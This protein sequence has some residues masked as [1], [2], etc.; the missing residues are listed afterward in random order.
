MRLGICQVPYQAQAWLPPVP[1]SDSW[2]ALRRLGITDLRLQF[3]LAAVSPS[4][5]AWNTA[6]FAQ[7][8]RPAR[9][10]GLRVCANIVM[11]EQLWRGEIP[12][13]HH[14]A[15]FRQE[16]ARRLVGELGDMIDSYG[17]GNEPGFGPWM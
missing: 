11:G 7:W 16:A 15:A 9:A 5:G 13:A 1:N 14:D 17:L 3:N 2:Q 6:L 4:P 8:L 12:P 10:A